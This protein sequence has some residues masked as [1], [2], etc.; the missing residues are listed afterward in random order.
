MK[1]I[2]GILGPTSIGK[3]AIAKIIAQEIKGQ[4]VSADSMQIYK[5]LNIG[6]AK[7]SSEELNGIVQHMVDIVDPDKNFSSFDYGLMASEI[8]EQLFNKSITPIMAGGT[9]FYFDSVLYPLAYSNNNV[10]KIRAQLNDL[11]NEHGEIFLHE[12]LK[13][14][15][16]LS[17]QN[18][19]PNNVKRVI[20][21]LEIY[22]S[23]GKIKSSHK[24]PDTP[25]YNSKLFV[26]NTERN[27]LYQR[28][29]KRVDKM[30]E[31]G[32]VE[33]VKKLISIY[34]PNSQAFTA[35]GYK[36]IIEYLNGICDLNQSI[37]NIKQHTRNYAKRQLTYFSRFKNATWVDVNLSDPSETA[38]KILKDFFNE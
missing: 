7:A 8:I 36:E 21:A 32:L 6:T 5:G 24:L 38:Q 30:I 14:I 23:T 16:P 13:E 15:D 35:I 11:L 12:K 19:H 33:E 26:L 3:T 1:K 9:G 20:R 25:K 4:I 18:I 17:A 2:L 27:A 31:L 34:P 37:E 22:Y 10:E 28:I 29:N